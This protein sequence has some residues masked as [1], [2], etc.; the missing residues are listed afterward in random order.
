MNGE[1]RNTIINSVKSF[2]NHSQMF[3]FSISDDGE[4]YQIIINQKSV[5]IEFKYIFIDFEGFPEP[6]KYFTLEITVWGEIDTIK[7]DLMDN[8]IR[9]FIKELQSAIMAALILKKDSDNKTAKAEKLQRK[10]EAAAVSGIF[11]QDE[12]I[13]NS[14]ND[15]LTW[16]AMA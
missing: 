1:T 4:N 2:C 14:F 16:E 13:E 9:E 5:E 10:L 8:H 7:Y 3:S 6:A 12:L 15:F 11:Y